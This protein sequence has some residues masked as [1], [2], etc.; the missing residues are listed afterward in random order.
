[1]LT[2]C[3][4]WLKKKLR[5]F[6]LD[7]SYPGYLRLRARLMPEAER[8]GVHD[9]DLS[10]KAVSRPL[11]PSTTGKAGLLLGV[12]LGPDLEWPPAGLEAF[13]G[14]RIDSLAQRLASLEYLQAHAPARLV[15]A[16]DARLTPDRGSIQLVAELA[17]RA[18]HC[19]ILPL[20]DNTAAGRPS[21]LPKWYEMLE[22][23]GFPAGSILKDLEV[24]RVWLAGAEQGGGDT[25]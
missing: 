12:E 23:V 21:R 10:V 25:L 7:A 9:P 13:A 17:D 1:M 6:A 19:R 4:A 11:S 16:I 20:G 18:V 22:T 2:F 14:G 8:L 3:G 24:V 15:L 5:M